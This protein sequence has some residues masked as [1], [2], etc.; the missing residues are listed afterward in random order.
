MA[1]GYHHRLAASQKL[2]S[3]VLEAGSSMKVPPFQAS[4]LASG[5]LR[6]PVACRWPS[7]RSVSSPCLP[8]VHI[9]LCV[10]ISPRGKATSHTGLE[11]TLTLF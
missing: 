11:P 7:S 2:L 4:L 10:P 5:S 6:S 3:E 1:L 8:S 9:C